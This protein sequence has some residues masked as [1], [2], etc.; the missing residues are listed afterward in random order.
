ML[1]NMEI[2]EDKT[3]TAEFSSQC[4]CKAAITIIT[5]PMNE[6]VLY[7][8][9]DNETSGI[10]FQHTRCLTSNQ[11]RRSNLANFQL[12]SQLKHKLEIEVGT[13]A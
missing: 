13:Y 7:C 4:S 10:K 5:S 11:L 6:I 1:Q 3:Y 9:I 2:H 12:K 8:I